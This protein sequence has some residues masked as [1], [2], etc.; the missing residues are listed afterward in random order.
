MYVGFVLVLASL[1]TG[2][3]ATER[4][5]SGVPPRTVRRWLTWWRTVFV[6]SALW[7]ELR[8]RILPPCDEGLLPASLFERFAP[9]SALRDLTLAL[10]PLTTGSVPDGSRFVR[11]AM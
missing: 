9:R 7:A 1:S 10:A 11:L 2:Q 6:A 8:A 3:H 4:M 5:S